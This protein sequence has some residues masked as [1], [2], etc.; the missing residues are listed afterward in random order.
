MMRDNEIY[1]T[2]CQGCLS[3]DTYSVRHLHSGYADSEVRD[4]DEIQ[5]QVCQSGVEGKLHQESAVLQAISP[6]HHI[7]NPCR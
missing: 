2:V 5:A 7:T 1:L 3:D 6:F 4:T